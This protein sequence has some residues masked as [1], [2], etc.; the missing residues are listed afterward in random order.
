[1]GEPLIGFDDKG[2]NNR[3]EQTSLL[4]SQV[5]V[6]DVNVND[7]YKHQEGV[8]FFFP[9]P[10]DILVVFLNG[11]C[12]R[13][14]TI[15]SSG[16]FIDIGLGGNLRKRVAEIIQTRLALIHSAVDC[17]LVVRPWSCNPFRM[18]YTAFKSEL[19]SPSVRRYSL[20]TQPVQ[21]HPWSRFVE[22]CWSQRLTI[23][24]Q[25]RSQADDEPFSLS[26][27]A[28]PKVSLEERAIEGMGAA[29]VA[30]FVGLSQHGRAQ[31]RSGLIGMVRSRM[32]DGPDPIGRNPIIVSTRCRFIRFMR[33]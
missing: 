9:V 5:N 25:K 31:D 19:K 18:A 2:G 23:T 30:K 8:N 6:S 32:S 24:K 33:R 10:H 16:F 17:R 3:G 11:F 4:T 7:T 1:M 27:T 15:R 13:R 20:K 28:I 21:Y 12:A 22:L 14:P 26:C 29:I